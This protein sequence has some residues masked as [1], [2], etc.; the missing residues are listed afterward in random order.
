MS[1][2]EITPEPEEAI[3]RGLVALLKAAMPLDEID[4][5]L[6][7]SAE[8]VVKVAGAAHVGV[9]VDLSDQMHDL[10]PRFSPCVYSARVTVRVPFA[11][12][13]TGAAFRDKCRIARAALLT[14]T[15]DG[16][17]ALDT[18]SGGA[19]K[20]HALTVDST[21]TSLDED[22]YGRAMVKTYNMTVTGVA[23]ET[24]TENTEKE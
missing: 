1:E 14:L 11:D 6:N 20:C 10:A 19:F 18:L 21:A 3:E 7:P 16:C 12:D 15:G 8:G 9:T 23:V 2:E 22:E 5:A 17:T 13:A 24:E 4:G